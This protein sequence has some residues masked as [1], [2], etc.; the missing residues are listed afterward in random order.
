MRTR[1]CNGED[2]EKLLEAVKETANIEQLTQTIVRE[3]ES[4]K[5]LSERLKAAGDEEL[6]NDEKEDRVEGK[7]ASEEKKMT[8]NSKPMVTKWSM[9]TVCKKSTTTILY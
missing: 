3:A 5:Q 2:E 4:F 9:G 8:L 1:L 6:L 7:E